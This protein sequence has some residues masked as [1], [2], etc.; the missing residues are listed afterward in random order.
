MILLFAFGIKMLQTD[1]ED[2][3]FTSDQQ[4]ELSKLGFKFDLKGHLFIRST[5]SKEQQL[6]LSKYGCK[7]DRY[8]YI[9]SCSEKY[10]S[11][12]RTLSTY[13]KNAPS[14]G[15]SIQPRSTASFSPPIIK[16]TPFTFLGDDIKQM[17]NLT[18]RKP[19]E[20]SN[21]QYFIEF[22]DKQKLGAREQYELPINYIERSSR[23]K[24]IFSKAEVTIGPGEPLKYIYWCDPN[25]PL[26]GSYLV[27]DKIESKSG[28]E[29][30]THKIY[31]TFSEENMFY[32]ALGIAPQVSVNND[33]I[34]FE[35]LIPMAYSSN[36][37][38]Y[39]FTDPLP[40]EW[41]DKSGFTDKWDQHVICYYRQFEDFGKL[42]AALKALAKAKF[43][44]IV[45]GKRK[46]SVDLSTSIPD[47]LKNVDKMVMEWCKKRH[48][49]GAS[50]CPSPFVIDPWSFLYDSDPSTKAIFD[51]V[52]KFVRNPPPDFNPF[53][54]YV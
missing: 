53:K 20:P 10:R 17:V 29:S 5:Y 19:L 52:A 36:D 28:K 12:A 22:Y 33:W 27:I 25:D 6:K 46:V 18:S 31:F 2:V 38:K 30:T 4:E 50:L 32:G 37:K 34:D 26:K 15:L 23:M 14:S 45:T 3:I 1:D 42:D 48:I 8:G 11:E 49:S 44:P 40:S 51:G 24:T 43:K 41:Y 54:T 39:N 21:R 47:Y 9:M 7:F 35:E 13:A 16:H